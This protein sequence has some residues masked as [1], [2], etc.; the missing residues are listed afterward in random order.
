MAKV[1]YVGDPND[2]GSGPDSVTMFGVTTEKGKTTTLPK[3]LTDEQVAKFEGNSHFEV[4]GGEKSAPADTADGGDLASTT[5]DPETA[6]PVAR[7]DMIGAPAPQP[8][9]AA[10]RAEDD[11]ERDAAPAAKRATKR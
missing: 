8:Q 9:T 2:N 4:T 7:T 6:L 5:G 3:S 1:K 11:A 10:Q